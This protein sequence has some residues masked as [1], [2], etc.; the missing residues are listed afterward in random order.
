MIPETNT[1]VA[2]DDA[3]LLTDS[4][5]AA[6]CNWIPFDEPPPMLRCT[7]KI[8]YRADPAAC[9]VTASDDGSAAVRFDE[10]QRAITP[11]QAVVF[12]DGD[13]CLGGGWIR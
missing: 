1:V 10:V 9:T 5:S 4:L 11:G 7:A 3:D 2:G 13:R 12:Y 8:R 6:D